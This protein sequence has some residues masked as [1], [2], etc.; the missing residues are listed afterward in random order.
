M[1]GFDPN[2]PQ[3]RKLRKSVVEKGAVAGTRGG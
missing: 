2:P 3:R 1:M